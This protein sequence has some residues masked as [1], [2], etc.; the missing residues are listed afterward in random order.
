MLVQQFNDALSLFL[1]LFSHSFSMYLSLSLP[2]SFSPPL[3][4]FFA[5]YLF[6]SLSLNVVSFKTCSGNSEV[7]FSI[8]LSL[9]FLHNYD[10][11]IFRWKRKQSF[12]VSRDLSVFSL[13]LSA[14]LIFCVFAFL[15][16]SEQFFILDVEAA[17]GD[18][19]TWPYF[20]KIHGLH[21]PTD[22]FTLGVALKLW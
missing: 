15:Y 19:K 11:L 10:L 3:P 12:I 20:Q 13:S 4:L 2:L 21:F 6:I 7:F 8:Y 18:K 5:F 22:F 16:L 14:F 1:F 9:P 17:A